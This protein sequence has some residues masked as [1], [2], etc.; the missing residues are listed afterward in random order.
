MQRL[1][2]IILIFLLLSL[3]SCISTAPLEECPAGTQ[4]LPDCPPA[5]AEDDPGINQLYA[6]RTWVPPQDLEMDLIELGKQAEIPIQQARTKILGPSDED[7]LNSLAAKLWMIERAEHTIDVVYYIF[8]R[9]LIGYA[10]L[11]ALCNAVRRG[12]DVRIMVDSVGSFHQNHNELRGLET[13]ADQAGFIRNA[14]GQVT[15]KKARV[16]VVIFNAITHQAANVN[17]RSHDKL[18]VV[19]GHFRDKAAVMTGGRN[20]SLDYYGL[21]NDGSRDPD[22]FRDVEI[23]VRPVLDDTTESVGELSEIY[24]T[25][26]FLFDANRRILPVPSDAANTLYKRERDRAIES[27]STLKAFPLVQERLQTMPRYMNE[28]FH[29]SHVLLAHELGNLTDTNVIEDAVGN[30]GRN[31]NSIMYLLDQI[32]ENEPDPKR[33]RLVSPYLFLAKYHDKDGNLVRDEAEDFMQ[34][35]RDN[36]ESTIEIITNSVLTSDNFSAQSVIDMDTAPRLLLTTALHDAWMGARETKNLTPELVT[37]EK[38]QSLMDNPRV[39]IYQTGKLDAAVFGNG[40]AYYG[41]L[42]A[43]YIVSDDISF[44]GTANFDY[45]SRLFNNEMGFFVDDVDVADDLNE[46]F[47]LLIADSYRWGSPEWMEMRRAVM[48]LSGMKGM[49]TRNQRGIYKTL[50]AT[51]LKWQF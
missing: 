5:F 21:Q 11:G 7:A 1:P 34:F 29:E 35:L 31:P 42:H 44:V 47:D 41:K 49:S 16:Q 43:K 38:W 10:V 2:K 17:R 26:L 8:K 22:P 48:N 12:V 39:H 19:D 51:G 32:S 24:Y 50:R 33:F 6:D 14:D 37:T 9:D 36:P 27:L 30:I 40:D 20:I 28:D 18:L 13:C 4:N 23:L 3:T 45:R 46:I 15:T 25:V